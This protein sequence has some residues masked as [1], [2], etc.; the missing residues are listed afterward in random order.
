MG[1]GNG[2]IEGTEPY[3]TTVEGPGLAKIIYTAAG[4][5][6]PIAAVKC[7]RVIGHNVGKDWSRWA[8]LQQ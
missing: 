1:A 6:L 8:G 7:P 2:L 4:S 5:R 3:E